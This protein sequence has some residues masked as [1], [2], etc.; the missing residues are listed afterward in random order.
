MYRCGNQYQDRP[1][2]AGQ[3]SRALG[4]ANPNATAVA[5]NVDRECTQRGRDSMRISWGREAGATLEKALSEN[6]DAQL[7]RDVYGKRGSAAEVRTAIEA[8][9][10]V[11]KEKEATTAAALKALGV[12]GRTPLPA[13]ALPQSSNVPAD[14]VKQPV[15][16]QERD[17]PAAEERKTEECRRLNAELQHIQSQQRVGGSAARMESLKAGQRKTLHE[18]TKAGC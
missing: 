13:P 10:Q 2:D 3:P 1:C 16:A 5:S 15:A 8:D 7:V 17:G 4:S 6:R 14:S 9:C 11:Q 18:L 12:D